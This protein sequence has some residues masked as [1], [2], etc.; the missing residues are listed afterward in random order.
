MTRKCTHLLKMSIFWAISF[1]NDSGLCAHVPP[2]LS[3]ACSAVFLVLAHFCGLWWLSFLT[4]EALKL[5]IRRWHL[6]VAGME[7]IFQ[8]KVCSKYTSY[9]LS[10]L[11]GMYSFDI[12]SLAK[13]I[14]ILN[15]SGFPWRDLGSPHGLRFLD[16]IH[17]GSY[18]IWAYFM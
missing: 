1:L 18:K 6:Q 9:C 5:S 12:A 16:V 11:W 15:S 10:L 8:L 14:I 7:S 3:I 2:Y 13:R 4:S 17:L